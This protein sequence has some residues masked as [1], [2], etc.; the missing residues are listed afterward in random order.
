MSLI[1]PSRLE[2]LR[3]IA[4]HSE[5]R[6]DGSP[7]YTEVDNFEVQY[8][9][10]SYAQ[11]YTNVFEGANSIGI[12]VSL[13][14]SRYAYSLPSR[15]SFTIILDATVEA[16]GLST[17]FADDA[18]EGIAGLVDRFLAVCYDYDGEIHQPRFLRVEWGTLSAP[19]RMQSV[20]IQYS[21]F[22]PD[23]TP[24]RAKLDCVFLGD[25]SEEI[26]I[27]Q[28]DRRSPDLAKLHEVIG[29]DSLPL[30]S[31]KAY[32]SSAYYLA[33]AKYNELDHF[34]D[35]QAGAQIRIPSLENLL[36]ATGMK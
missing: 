21:M 31:Q 25:V 22:D 24:I 13:P 6:G 30:I 1:T 12:N 17:A 23:G 8:D 28:E 15:L 5:D 35:L 26:R 4:F 36:Q 16:G 18:G 34:R 29:G 32:G 2:P 14:S 9:P 11:Q 7:T 19:C 27:R 20:D 3:I 33:L 10:S